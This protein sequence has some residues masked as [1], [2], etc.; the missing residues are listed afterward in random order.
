[1]DK[2][3]QVYI[4]TTTGMA[5]LQFVN[6]MTIHHWSGCGDGHKDIH[7][8]V[9]QILMNPSYADTKDRILKCEVLIID[10]IGLLSCK[11]FKSIEFICR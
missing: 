5:R 8:L 2:Q 9:E 10:E 1:M 3:H 11:G 6:A 7:Q 4:T